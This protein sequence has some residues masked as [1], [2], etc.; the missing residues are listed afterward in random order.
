MPSPAGLPATAG[1]ID[2]WPGTAA[3]DRLSTCHDDS[4]APKL[5]LVF[6]AA[7]EMSGM[8]G[9]SGF[10]AAVLPSPLDPQSEWKTLPLHGSQQAPRCQSAPWQSPCLQQVA[11]GGARK[12]IP[13]RRKANGRVRLKILKSDDFRTSLNC[14]EEFGHVWTMA[15]TS[16]DPHVPSA[17]VLPPN[18]VM[19]NE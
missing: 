6:Q 9:M 1:S 7:S 15:H 10:H 19:R 11:G 12:P 17:T 13:V 14:F 5:R 4:A 3:A 16:L 18:L 2:T 8:S